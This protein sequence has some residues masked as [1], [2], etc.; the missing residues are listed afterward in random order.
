M[1]IN[2]SEML[3]N[4]YANK[5]I[6]IKVFHLKKMPIGHFHVVATLD[7][8]TKSFLAEIHLYF[9]IFVSYQKKMREESSFKLATFMYEQ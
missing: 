5:Q 9:R 2:E 8:N 3:P 6:C 1:K 7:K 4:W